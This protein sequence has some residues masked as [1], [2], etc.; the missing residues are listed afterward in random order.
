[1]PSVTFRRI[2]FPKA[3]IIALGRVGRGLSENPVVIGSISCPINDY[4]D[5]HSVI[6][7]TVHVKYPILDSPHSIVDNVCPPICAVAIQAS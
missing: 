7:G 2:Y 5:L 3:L 6:N 1:M 4:H